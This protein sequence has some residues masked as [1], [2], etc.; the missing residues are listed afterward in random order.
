MRKKSQPIKRLVSAAMS[1]ILTGSMVAGGFFP[2]YGAPEDGQTFGRQPIT[3][4]P[5]EGTAISG[6]SIPAS[7][8]IVDEQAQPCAAQLF[9]YL[10][11]V[12]ESPYVLY[13]HQNDTHHK[14]GEE[15][16]GST[17]SDTKDITGSISAIVGIDALSFTGAELPIPD[18]QKNGVAAAAQLSIQAAQEGAIMTLSAHMPNFS[19]VADKGQD[20]DGSYDYSGYTPGNTKGE[21]MSRILPGGDLNDVYNGYLDLIADYGLLLQAQGI[22]VLFRPLHENNGSWFWWGAAFCDEEGYKNVYRYTV[23]YLRDVKNVHNFL[24]VYSPGGP[25]DSMADFESR[26]PGDEYVDVIGFDMYHD[27]PTT[28]DTW[29]QSFAQTAQLIDQAAQIHGKVPVVAETGMRVGTSLNDG[30]DYGGIAPEGNARPLWFSEIEQILSP[31]NIPYY[32]VW[33][34]W[35]GANNFYSPYKTSPAAG[36]EMTDAF[37]NY[38]NEETSVFANGTG[39]YGQILT[40]AVEQHTASGYILSPASGARILY[41]ET[42]T[43]SVEHIGGDVSFVLTNKE[44]TVSRT[45]PAQLSGQEDKMGYVYQA[46]MSQEDLKEL[47]KTTGTISLVSGGT[48]LNTINAIFNIKE[49]VLDPLVVDDFE[50]YL[51]DSVLLMKDWATNSGSGC[52]VNLELSESNKAEKDFGMAFRYVISSD[53]SGEGWAGATKPFESNLTSCNALQLWIKPDGRGQKL[54]IQL[55]SNGEDFE[56][57]LPEFAAT[58]EAK[59]VTVPFA[60]MQGKNGGVFDP[61]NISSFGIWCNTISPEGV[62]N[63]TVD[64]VLYVD[65]IHAVTTDSA[66]VEYLDTRTNSDGSAGSQVETI[67]T[68]MEK[69]LLWYGPGY[70]GMKSLEPEPVTVTTLYQGTAGGKYETSDPSWLLNGKDTDY[71]TFVYNCS[72]VNKA[73]WSVLGWGATVNGTW[74][75]GPRYNAPNPNTLQDT[76]IMVSV[77]E[78]KSVL[79]IERGSSVDYL[80]LGTWN[81]GNLKSITLT[82]GQPMPGRV[83]VENVPA[84]YTYETNDVGWIVDA[85]DDKYINLVITCDHPKHSEWEIMGWGASVGDDWVEG[86]KYTAWKPASHEYAVSYTVKRFKELLGVTPERPLTYIKLGSYNDGRIVRL[87]LDDTKTPFVAFYSWADRHGLKS[88]RKDPAEQPYTSP[89]AGEYRRLIRM[90][91]NEEETEKVARFAFSG[92]ADGEWDEVELDGDSEAQAQAAAEQLK[93]GSFIVIEYESSEAPVLLPQVDDYT[94][95]QVTAAYSG[96]G[97]AVYL[98]DKIAAQLPRHLIPAEITGFKVKAG[99]APVKIKSLAVVNDDSISAEDES[100]IVSGKYQQHPLD[101]F[102]YNPSYEE[103][104]EVTVSI[105]FDRSVSGNISGNVNGVWDSGNGLSGTTLTRTFT[106]DGSG[107][108]VSLSEFGGT[109]HAKITNVKVDIA[110]KVNYESAVAVNTN[111]TI[112]VLKSSAEEI[113]QAAGLTDEE[114]ANGSRFEVEMKKGT[115]ADDTKALIQQAAEEQEK[116]AEVFSAV[117]I[118]GYRISYTGAKTE[119]NE[120]GEPARYSFAVPEGVDS[121]KEFVIARIDDAAEVESMEAMLAGEGVSQAGARAAAGKVVTWLDDLDTNPK[122]ITVESDKFGTFVLVAGEGLGAPSEHIFTGAWE[123][124]ETKLSNYFIGADEPD[125]FEPGRETNIVVTFNE[126][127]KAQIAVN[128]ASGWS[129]GNELT[130]KVIE[131]TCIPSDDYLNLQISDMMGSTKVKVLRV[132]VRQKPEEAGDEITTFVG[133]YQ[134][135]ETTFTEFNK[136][137]APGKETTVTLTFDQEVEAQIGYHNT[138]NG[139]WT[140]K[141]GSAAGKVISVKVTSSD[142]YLNIQ[143][144]DMKGNAKVKLLDVKVEQEGAAEEPSDPPVETFTKPENDNWAD[145]KEVTGFKKFNDAFKEGKETTLTLEFDKE[146]TVRAGYNNAQESGNVDAPWTSQT[147]TGKVIV[148]T[149]TPDDDYLGIQL[150][151]MKE[152]EEIKLLSVKVEQKGAAEEPSDPP[153]EAFTKPENDNWVDSKEVTGFKKFNDAFKEGKETTLTLEF[154]KEVTVRAG[155]NNAQESGN[156]DAPWTSQTK[157]GKVIVFTITPDD[158]YLGIQLQN[159]KENEEIKLLSVKVEQSGEQGISTLSADDITI[160]TDETDSFTS[161]IAEWTDDNFASDQGAVIKAEF[162]QKVKAKI[163]VKADGEWVDSEVLEG[164]KIQAAFDS[165]GEEFK[166]TVLALKE[167]EKAELLNIAITNTPKKAAKA[168]A[169]AEQKKEVSDSDEQKSDSEEAKTPT[170][171]PESEEK[172]P[173]ADTKKD[174]S[175]KENT[176]S[177]ETGTKKDDEQKKEE[178]SEDGSLT[179]KNENKDE[180]EP[181]KSEG[182][183]EPEKTSKPE[184]TKKSEDKQDSSTEGTKDKEPAAPPVKSDEPES[185]ADANDGED[186]DEKELTEKKT[187]APAAK[188]PEAEADESSEEGDAD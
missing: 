169:R 160:F 126:E 64:S 52:S 173:A 19:L 46:K 188:K 106:P 79:G 105:T 42:L 18:G 119:V 92:E 74:T 158:D 100:D 90:V 180:K 172:T 182:T 142:D 133:P 11:A 97:Y 29:M 128:T 10:K 149:I 53:G 118:S 4:V 177:T 184:E 30:K 143:L 111:Q 41:P 12:G 67:R 62:A 76:T 162:A 145:S 127:V 112:S 125:K 130:G 14:G 69:P 1:V 148:F 138:T 47:G 185:S 85:P 44:G 140:E 25:F 114:I 75:E 159:M 147:K 174:T 129:A 144:I 58:T 187:D 168:P 66:A 38:Y 186:K 99:G 17:S 15:Y 108:Y 9:A 55:T 123:G 36:H 7:V 161:D 13:G 16:F 40:P 139:E 146:V 176:S 65:D 113:A 6:L 3:A 28:T 124:W 132:E 2:A 60:A 80:N 166:I 150:Q 179:E 183:A 120:L 131:R 56:V 170:N 175:D 20:A 137:Y 26:Y 27:N 171:A 8:R 164:K 152:N 178:D 107:I 71:V 5:G 39:F 59:Y 72:D 154:D 141:K 122:T 156:V 94:Y 117:D 37:I 167:G 115:V 57:H 93:P 101:L 73:G 49:A 110:G 68:A 50:G 43:A 82:K 155:Y 78:L 96:D 22:P 86:P 83:I 102:A 95:N 35:D 165:F 163:S 89:Y 54:V 61:A 70:E 136:D 23:E 153:V 33:A 103:G 31:T 109:N 24:Y 51:G 21:V 104:D 34:N 121:E 151:N 77:K 134:G 91:G 45:I 87:S 181:V 63:W 98:L 116:E 157:T 32:M 81:D 84:N 135:F 48:V 88:G